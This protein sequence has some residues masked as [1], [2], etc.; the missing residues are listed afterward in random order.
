MHRDVCLLPQPR[1]IEP[2]HGELAVEPPPGGGLLPDVSGWALDRRIDPAAVPHAQGYRLTV[3]PEGI[4]LE[5]ADEAGAFY[6]LQTLRQLAAWQA[7]R[8]RL[9][10]VCVE[11][12][13]DFPARGAMLDISR[14]KVPTMSTLF[15]L[16]D[17]LA[18]WKINQLQLYTE[19]TF[20]YAGHEAVWRD[21][22]PM[23]PD[24]VEQLDRFC[25]Q[26]FVEL[27]PNQNSFGH[28]ERWLK[29]D[30]YARLAEIDGPLRAR[31]GSTPH[32]PA[33]LCPLDPGSLHLLEN[34]Y[35]QLLPHFTS[36]M[37]NVGCDETRQLG[38]G[39]SRQACESRGV[40]RVYLDFL[41]Q[42]HRLVQ[43]HG[44]TMQFWCDIMDQHAELLDELP[45]DAIALEWGYEPRHPFGQ[46]GR[47]LAESGL[48]FYVCPGTSSWNSI[49]GRTANAMLNLRAAAEQGRQ[50]GAEGFL[51][52]DWGD[53]G[54]WQPLPVSYLGFAHGAAV[55]WCADANGD[56]DIA[57]RL[58]RYAFADSAAV[59]GQLALDLGN[60]YRR[61]GGML[62]NRSLLCH[63]LL[64]PRAALRDDPKATADG[65]PT[66]EHMRDV[67]DD[68]DGILARLAEARMSRRDAGLV[69]DEFR[70]AGELMRHAAALGEARLAGAPEAQVHELPARVRQEL[71]A[72]LRRLIG[73]LR[74]TWLAR[75]RP[76]G[77]K[78]SV[79]RLERLLKLYGG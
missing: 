66:V 36:R 22:S 12:W 14:D 57:E 75:N 28:M 69:R 6:A 58:D 45:R 15:D 9:P 39:R 5:A 62:R 30:A 54:H 2:L 70:F 42:I 72:D 11:D 68:I 26:R 41:K 4:R 79:A 20:A 37:F 51:I 63:M 38:Q 55:S 48:R 53:H 34:L 43:D 10:C 56:V 32:Q 23:T 47:R 18:S 78:D 44:R 52:T 1:S 24:E 50:A 35:A 8:Q 31:R 33:T 77:L 59:M 29:H 25:R 71:A 46:R 17:L 73:A 7:D 27:V 19:H 60:V 13:P 76:G 74:E 65:A 64:R 61:A 40:G 3:R 16:V 21:A 67:R 49:G